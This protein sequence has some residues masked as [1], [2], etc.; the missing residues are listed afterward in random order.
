MW[1]GFGI[2]RFT[3]AQAAQKFKSARILAANAFTAAQAAQ[4]VWKFA[5]PRATRF[6]AAQ[7]A[8]KFP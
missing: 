2:F 7:A 6:T 3:A 5:V 4:K 8:Q 1:N